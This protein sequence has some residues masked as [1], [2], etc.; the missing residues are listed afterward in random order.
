MKQLLSLL[1][2]S[3]TIT[4]QAQYNFKPGYYIDH[5]GDTVK[6]L[7]NSLSMRSN[8]EKCEFKTSLEAA[9]IIFLPNQIQSYKFEDGKYYISKKFKINNIE[10]N[11]FMEVL[12]KGR[13]SCYFAQTSDGPAYFIEKDSL[14]KELENKGKNIYHNDN[15]TYSN[16]Y[17]GVLKYYL[18]D[19]PEVA[20]EANN[21]KLYRDNL[22]SLIAKYNK[23]D[24]KNNRYEIFQNAKR[25]YEWGIYSVYNIDYTSINPYLDSM[26]VEYDLKTNYARS[27]SI[28]G[29]VRMNIP[30]LDER[31]FIELSVLGGQKKL[32]GYEVVK[33]AL[34]PDKTQF[35]NYRINTNHSYLFTTLDFNCYYFLKYK[36]IMPYLNIGIGGTIR[37]SNKYTSAVTYSSSPFISCSS[38]YP[39]D[40]H[41][42]FLDFPVGAGFELPIKNH[43]FK[44]K[45]GYTFNT[46]VSFNKVNITNFNSQ[47]ILG[48]VFK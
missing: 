11:I 38:F 29:F 30:S 27:I 21:C 20:E 18:K 37:F 12:I 22:I 14:I 42:S 23:N 5:K 26:V 16:R 40:K 4:L 36:Y 2:I 9:T 25:I 31:F 3:I 28:G 8:S 32:S 10:Q 34:D 45:A 35:E 19:Q 6:G 43:N 48:I 24:I 33:I 1:F 46:S 39:A 44:L 15:I 17:I 47:I 41:V 7:I 13:I